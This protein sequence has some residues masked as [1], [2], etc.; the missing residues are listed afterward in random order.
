[1]LAAARAAQPARVIVAFQ[2]HRY[3]RTRDLMREFGLALAAADEVVLTDIY[4]ASED[5]IPGVTDRGAGRGDQHQPRD[6]G[7]DRQAARRRWRRRWPTLARPGDLVITLGAGSIGGVAAQVVRGARSAGK[8]AGGDGCTDACRC[9]S[10][11]Q[12]LP[13]RARQ[14]ARKRQ[15]QRCVTPGCVAQGD[16]PSSA[17]RSTAAGAARR[18]CSARR[19][20]RCRASRCAAT[21][22]C[23]PARC[24]R[25][26][27]GLRGRNI[28]T[29]DLDEWRA[30]LLAS[31]WV[32]DA[33][34]RRMLPGRDRV[35]IRER[36]PIGIGRVAGVALPGRRQRRRHRR[37]RTEL[38]ASSTC[39]SST[40]WR[41]RPPTAHGAIDE[42]RAA[43][44]AA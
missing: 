41:R 16:R 12:A 20:C 25:I 42:R 14:A 18:S 35:E 32:E 29:V 21:S 33:T 40:A 4:A 10:G 23:R 30:R 34:L 17:W 36:R 28:L 7:P 5:P 39:R 19:R 11:R 27:D 1:M 31:P 24:W 38:R 3:T 43:G 2:P 8:R 13:P 6:A 22:G 37:V 26:V 9:R 44:G 15:R